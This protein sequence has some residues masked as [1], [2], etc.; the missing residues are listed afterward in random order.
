MTIPLTDTFTFTE[1]RNDNT[2]DRH[3]YDKE[4]PSCECEKDDEVA[5][6]GPHTGKV[7]GTLKTLDYYEGIPKDL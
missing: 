7:R 6:K 3:F 4:N 2:I 5:K 1:R